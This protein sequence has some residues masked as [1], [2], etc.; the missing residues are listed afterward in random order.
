MAFMCKDQ[1]LDADLFRYFLHS[2]LWQD[3]AEK[4]M[5]ADQIDAVDITV[6][7]K[8]LP[9]APTPATTAAG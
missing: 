2:R 3:Y 6:I 7:E 8:L 1:H 5:K 9:S 4:F